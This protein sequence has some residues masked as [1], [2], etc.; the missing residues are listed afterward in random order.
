MVG[1]NLLAQMLA[2]YCGIA[3]VRPRTI[4]TT[5]LGAAFL[6]AIGS[7]QYR[8][9]DEAAGHWYADRRFEPRMAGDLRDRDVARWQEAVRRVLA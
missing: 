2:D 1:N 9:L 7:R 3:V 6:A 8:N 4:E 5:A